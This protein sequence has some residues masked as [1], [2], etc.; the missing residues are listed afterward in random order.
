MI[1]ARI[2]VENGSKPRS[3]GSCRRC[4]DACS[5]FSAC[6]VG[7]DYVKPKTEAPAAYKEAAEW[8]VAEPQEAVV[9]GT[10]WKIF[11]DPQLDA[12]EE[13]VNVSNQNVAAAEA[14]F[15]QARAAVQAARAGYFPTVS[16]GAQA[17]RSLQ[18]VERPRHQCRSVDGPGFRLAV[19]GN[20]LVGAGCLGQGAPYCR[21]EPG[22]RPGKRCG[23]ANRSASAPRL[24]WRKTISS[25]APSTRRRSSSTKRLPPIRK[26][27]S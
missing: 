26:L 17:T 14:Q 10:W 20:G 7:P 8:K 6:A 27:W 3:H 25:S 9:R 23:P 15:R 5:F 16:V 24:P 13:Q 4:R 22:R 2:R 11:K 19:D 21:S 18:I 1:R 12:L